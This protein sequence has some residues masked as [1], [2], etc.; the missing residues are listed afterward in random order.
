M[1]K[2][3][4]LYPLFMLLVMMYNMHCVQAANCDRSYGPA[5]TVHC[6]QSSRYNDYQ[7]ATCRTDNY[8]RTKSN[9]RHAC[10]DRTRT[11]CYYQCMI[12]VYDRSSGDVFL[13]CKC[14]PFDPKPTQRVKLP[15]WCYSPD[16]TNCNWYSN[17]LKKAYPYCENDKDDYSI[18]YTEKFCRLYDDQYDKFSQKGAQWINAVR[19]CIQ[20]KLVPLV[21]KTRVRTCSDL[22]YTAFKTHSPCYTNPENS[23]SSSISYCN[24]SPQDRNVVFWTIKSAFRAAYWPS[25][26]GLLDVRRDCENREGS[27]KQRKVQ[28]MILEE[29]TREIGE[30]KT[31]SVDEKIRETEVRIKVWLRNFV[32]PIQ[33]SMNI[34]KHGW[35]S[36]R[37]KR[38]APSNQEIKDSKFAGKV[39]DAIASQGRWQ[40]KGITWFAYAKNEIG[41]DHTKSIR[42]FVA[43]RYKYKD[44]LGTIKPTTI[45]DVLIQLSTDILNGTLYVSV[46]GSSVD[47]VKLNGCLDMDCD[48]HAFDIESSGVFLKAMHTI[49]YLIILSINFIFV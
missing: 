28:D 37:R 48:I 18:M 45:A 49:A 41:Q 46:D 32:S 9:G 12:D 33:L 5:G 30:T 26:K 11:Y 1:M 25:L 36:K 4:H 35:T 29:V 8:V 34:N 17:C 24:L 13:N 3:F 23:Q 2:S 39:I 21:D 44:G 22:K 19:K 20:L 47:I 15:D 43:D 16:G 40:E 6:I 31:N 42:F 10:I 7:W 27:R 38:S 14:S